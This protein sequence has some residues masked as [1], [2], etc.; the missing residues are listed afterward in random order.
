MRVKTLIMNSLLSILYDVEHLYLLLSRNDR[1][2]QISKAFY[3]LKI[4]RVR[5]VLSK[6]GRRKI[7]FR[8]V[9]EETH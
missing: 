9:L 4:F 5:S 6:E 1:N 3:I 7:T 2:Y 8:P